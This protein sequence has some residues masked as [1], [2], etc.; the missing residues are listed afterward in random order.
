MDTPLQAGSYE[1]LATILP[2]NGDIVNESSFLVDHLQIS[3]SHTLHARWADLISLP[4][5]EI[6]ISDK[7]LLLTLYWKAEQPIDASY[8]VFVH[9]IDQATGEIKVQH[10]AE[11]RD[12]SYPTNQ[13]AP[14][15]L[16]DDTIYLSLDGLPTGDYRL[17]TGFYDPST[18]QRLGAYSAQ[19]ELISDDIVILTTFQHQ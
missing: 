1:L 19:G 18:G 4:S 8:K 2:A 13:W 14:G 3:P 5:H 11:P 9:V 17:Q 12:W 7:W 16:V 15:E 10:D 6:A